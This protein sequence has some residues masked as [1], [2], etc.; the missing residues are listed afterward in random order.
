MRRTRGAGPP[1]GPGASMERY[2]MIPKPAYVDNLE[3]PELVAARR[4]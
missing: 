3:I 4:W 2:R 1:G